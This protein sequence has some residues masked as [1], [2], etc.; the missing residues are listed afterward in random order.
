M[1]WRENEFVRLTEM[2]SSIDDSEMFIVGVKGDET[3]E[4]RRRVTAFGGIMPLP[5]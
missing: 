2:K 4:Q 3:D 5:I 1:N